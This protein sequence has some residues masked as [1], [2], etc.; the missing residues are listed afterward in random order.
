MFKSTS[1]SRI[2]EFRECPLKAKLKFLDKVEDPRPELPEGKEHPMDRGSR[3]H[4]L[5][6]RLV[7]SGEIEQIPEELKRFENRFETLC[8]L[9]NQGVCQ[10]EMPVAFNEQWQQSDPKDFQNT[11]YRMIADVFIDLDGHIVVIDHKTGRKEGNEPI[12]MQQGIEY[13]CAVYMI[14]PS[15][16]K[17]TFEVWYLDKGDVLT[18]TFTRAEIADHVASFKKRHEKL[19]KTTLFPPTPSLQACLFCPFKKG[20]VGRG[21]NAYPGT[22]HCDKNVN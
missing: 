1:F 5:A 11:R 8:E 15:A 3:I 21:K 18:A 16:Q 6:E 13:L 20:T 2:K 19:W 4:E 14:Y 17:F 22:G 12:H 7:I 10:T 9:Y